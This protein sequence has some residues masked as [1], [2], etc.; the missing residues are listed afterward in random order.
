[1]MRSLKPTAAKVAKPKSAPYKLADGGG[2]Y[3]LV[4]PSGTKLWR[5][6]FRL[7]GKEQ[8]YS[9]GSYPELGLAQAREE[10]E[11][12][13]Q[14]VAQGVSPVLARRIRKQKQM[15]ESANSFEAIAREWY[16]EVAPRWS[17]YYANQVRVTLERDVFSKVGKLKLRDVT[18][19]DLRPILKSVAVRTAL[20]GRKRKRDRGAATVAILIR[21][22]CSAI[23]RYGVAIGVADGDPAY[24][25]KGLITRPK[26][27]HHRHLIAKELPE[28]LTR[29][30]GFT[31]TSE[32]KIAIQLLLLTFVR[33]GELRNAEWS[34]VDVDHCLW[35][36]PARKMKMR[37]EHLVPL[38]SQSLQ[39]IADLRQVTGTSAYLFPNQR[40]PRAVMSMTTVNRALERIG[41]GG[42]VSGHGFRGTASTFLNES[43]YSAHLIEKQLAHDKRNIVE[44]SYNHA[45]YLQ[46]RIKMMQFWGDFLSSDQSNIIP[47][48]K[49]A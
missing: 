17:A 31:G 11:K 15:A 26:V 9:L 36:I 48:K 34:E 28:F 46:E 27:Q 19:A 8:T 40:T 29:V 13:R 38:S 6:K 43:G 45:E 42:R 18:A 3:L 49:T 4:N 37:R 10:H 14:S 32:V 5:Y 7:Q 21:Q 23:F 47:I 25:L 35:R 16:A 33:T 2:L 1:M 12:A 41:Y 22:W 39:L 30:D 24:A 20:P 44:A